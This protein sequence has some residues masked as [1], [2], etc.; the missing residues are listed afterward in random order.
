MTLLFKITGFLMII[1]TTSAIGFLKSNELNLRYKKLCRIQKSICDLK[2][3]IRLH[4]GEIDRLINLSFG[5]YPINYQYLEKDEREILEEFFLGLGMSDTDAE[6]KRCELYI[7][8]LKGKT[9]ESRQKYLELNR[10]YKSIG[11]FSGIFICI[12]LL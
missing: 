9:N 7:D 4:A 11:V 8:L 3:R 6:Y 10:L 1:F 12:F 2:E 5:E